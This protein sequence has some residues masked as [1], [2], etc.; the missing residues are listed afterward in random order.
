MK[1]KITE[2]LLK[3]EIAELKQ[4]NAGLIG[5]NLALQSKLMKLEKFWEVEE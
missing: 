2:K 3:E 4:Q 5:D 1:D